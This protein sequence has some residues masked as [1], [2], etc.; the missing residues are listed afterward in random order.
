MTLS[1]E[2]RLDRLESERDIRRLA[3][4]YCFAIDAHDLDTVAELFCADA[5][6]RS[7]DGVMHAVGRDAIIAQYRGRFSV[8]GP[9]NHI[10]HDYLVTFDPVALDTATGQ[11]SAHAELWRN[12]MMMITALRYDDR[13]R[14][15]GGVWRIA[16]RVISFLYYVPVADYPAVL[17]L[18]DRNRAG[19]VPQAADYPEALPGWCDYRKS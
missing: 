11:L 6:V 7:S 15:D 10:S 5:V 13:Y 16:E 12:E 17:G 2:R 3:A 9:S 18:R 19:A 8:L 14:R 1:L 4:S